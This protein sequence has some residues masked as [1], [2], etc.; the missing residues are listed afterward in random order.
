MT[1]RKMG[2]KGGGR[3]RQTDRQGKKKLAPKMNI[4]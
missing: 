4:T 3:K 2:I 1:K